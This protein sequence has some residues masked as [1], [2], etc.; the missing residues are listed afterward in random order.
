M[1][2]ICAPLLAS[3]FVVTTVLF[4]LSVPGWADGNRKTRFPWHPDLRKEG[5]KGELGPLEVLSISYICVSL[6]DVAQT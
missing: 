4:S 3:S 6:T 5:T 2:T 1:E